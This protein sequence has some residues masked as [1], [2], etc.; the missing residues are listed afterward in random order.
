MIYLNTNKLSYHYALAIK[1]GL[2]EDR[3]SHLSM[4][5]HNFISA[6]NNELYKR[7]ADR[8]LKLCIELILRENLDK[9]YHQVLILF[10]AL[11]AMISEFTNAF[12]LSFI[13]L[14]ESITKDKK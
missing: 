1:S 9:G 8:G 2:S 14:Y 4:Q 6:E 5:L 12:K 3:K 10:S 13:E 7:G 11:K